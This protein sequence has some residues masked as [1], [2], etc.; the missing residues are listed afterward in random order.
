MEAHG[1]GLASMMSICH[2]ALADHLLLS[3]TKKTLAL[4]NFFGLWFT[5]T[6]VHE[7]EIHKFDFD[8]VLSLT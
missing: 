6:S 4:V 5:I 3:A 1:S 2:S 8:Q 7:T